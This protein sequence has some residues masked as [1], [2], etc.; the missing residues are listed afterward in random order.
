MSES[1]SKENN[2]EKNSTEAIKPYLSKNKPRDP[3]TA[4][5]PNR[6]K[7][8]KDLFGTCSCGK[9]NLVVPKGSTIDFSGYCHCTSCQKMS[10]S[11]FQ[12]DFGVPLDQLLNIFPIESSGDIG[13]TRITKNGPKRFYC[14]HCSTSLY[15]VVEDMNVICVHH[16][17]FNAFDQVPPT[18]HCCYGER[19]MDVNDGIIKYKEFPPMEAG[20]LFDVIED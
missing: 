11:P 12:C 3:Q 20:M 15:C 19:V 13:Y 14:K 18:Y 5:K 8:T 7:T 6:D 9:I 1:F 4:W 10:S 16:S 17:P 2:V